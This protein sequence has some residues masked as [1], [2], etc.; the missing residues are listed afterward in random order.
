MNTKAQ[1]ILFKVNFAPLLLLNKICDNKLFK[2]IPKPDIL[3]KFTF[4]QL[5][6]N[7][8]RSFKDENDKK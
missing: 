6:Y 1:R 4:I 7:S 8:W 5:F 2:I 3:P